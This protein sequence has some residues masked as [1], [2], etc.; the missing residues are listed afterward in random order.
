[1]SGLIKKTYK[2][3]TAT[4]ICGYCQI[5]ITCEN[6]KD[7]YCF[8]NHKKPTVHYG[9]T[10]LGS[11]FQPNCSSSDDEHLMPSEH[12]ENPVYSTEQKHCAVA[13]VV[14]DAYAFHPPAKQARLEV[15]NMKKVRKVKATVAR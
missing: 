4:T 6:L 9:Q 2:S 10:T 11:L 12:V 1:M 7:M 3:K 8:E 15:C 14:P 5:H 13:A